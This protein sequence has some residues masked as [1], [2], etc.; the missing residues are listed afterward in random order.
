MAGRHHPNSAATILYTVIKP[1][2]VS[3]TRKVLLEVTALEV[4][5][6]AFELHIH[7]GAMAMWALEYRNI[8]LFNGNKR[9]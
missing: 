4:I 5:V 9:Q 1:P 8:C 7:K 3:Y 6:D 2:P